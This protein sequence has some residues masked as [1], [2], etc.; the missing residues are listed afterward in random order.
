MD[1][2]EIRVIQKQSS[3]SRVEPVLDS[4]HSSIEA[5]RTSKRSTSLLRDRTVQ[6]DIAAH[7]LILIQKVLSESKIAK[8]KKYDYDHANDIKNVIHK[9]DSFSA[10]KIL[11]SF[12]YRS[13]ILAFAEAAYLCQLKLT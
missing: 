7:S 8:N 4:S 1:R 6:C 5:I 9:F 12:G 13:A 10:K 2:H 3:D 11:S